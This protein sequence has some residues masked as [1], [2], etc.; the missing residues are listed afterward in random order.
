MESLI[1]SK[2]PNISTNTLNQYKKQIHKILKNLDYTESSDNLEEFLKAN[3]KK[4]LEEIQQYDNPST[5]RNFLNSFITLYKS[6]DDKT[7]EQ[8]SKMRDD[9]HEKF[10]NN[11]KKN[12]EDI[13]GYI[14]TT[15]YESVY[16]KLK[17]QSKSLTKNNKLEK[18]ELN[19]LTDFA[20]VSIYRNTNIRA[21]IA[22]TL[23]LTQTQYSRSYKNNTTY[24]YMVIKTTKSQLILN[25]YKTSK[26]LGVLKLDIDENTT[27]DLKLYT[28]H[29]KQFMNN[30]KKL[31]LIYDKN[32][33]NSITPNSLSQRFT[34][35]FKENGYSDY[36]INLNRKRLISS[37]EHYK[38]YVELK[39][40]LQKTAKDSGHSI[41][42][43]VNNY[44]KS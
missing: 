6:I 29:L 24:N 42:V 38:N 16:N 15:Q 25:N 43:A 5:Q 19:R 35:I 20:I 12:I 3:S 4:I 28:K 44:F 14:N 2:K 9:N 39:E 10:K 30:P 36:S 13:K 17:E 33:N 22:D 34:S 41:G 1:K 32:F 40:K 18:S 23:V 26:T 11:I 8:F 37:N 31:F 27:N 21:D 7:Y